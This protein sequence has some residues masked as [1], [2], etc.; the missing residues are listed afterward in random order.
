MA[1][2]FKMNLMKKH[3]NKGKLN[4]LVFGTLIHNLGKDN[5]EQWSEKE[6]KFLHGIVSQKRKKKRDTKRHSKVKSTKFL[7]AKN[8][9]CQDFCVIL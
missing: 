7:N 3:K 9:S 8:R 5:K 6:V 1:S 2:P 4:S